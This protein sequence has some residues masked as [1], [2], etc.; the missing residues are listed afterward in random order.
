MSGSG[1]RVRVHATDPVRRRGFAELIDRYFRRTDRALCNQRHDALEMVPVAADM[2][3]QRHHIAA[4]RL[5]RL[6]AGADEGR[7]QCRG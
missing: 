7:A 1:L 2:G 4:V 3:P 5:W 6:R